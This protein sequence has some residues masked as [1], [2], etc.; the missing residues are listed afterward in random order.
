MTRAHHAGAA[1]SR[2]AAPVMQNQNSKSQAIDPADAARAL[3]GLFTAATSACRRTAQGR[4][5]SWLRHIRA[6]LFRQKRSASSFQEPVA[7]GSLDLE[8]CVM[9]SHLPQ[10]PPELFA[11][12]AMSGRRRNRRARRRAAWSIAEVLWAGLTFCELG[13]SPSEAELACKLGP[14]CLSYEQ[15]LSFHLLHSQILR[16][17]RLK[18]MISRGTKLL[19][20]H[21]VFHESSL[22]GSS[23]TNHTIERLSKTTA[24]PVLSAR[25]KIPKV[26]AQVCPEDFLTGERRYL[27]THQE[28]L[29]LKD[30]VGP[31]APR[32]HMISEVEEEKLRLRLFDAGAAAAFPVEDI[33]TSQGVDLVSGL[34]AVPHSEDYDRLIMDRRPQ[35]SRERRLQWL[36]LPL[37]AMLTRVILDDSCTFRGSGYDLST[38]FSLGKFWM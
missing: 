8:K 31:P 24:R 2:L 26:A 27:F 20:A 4:V 7:P 1:G 21:V 13:G 34:F 9:P 18:P 23:A 28:E 5:L 36:Q 6:Q 11:P 3:D 25:A 22:L 10:Q 19:D 29:Q 38:Y 17:C 12:Q 30:P 14:W 35:H 16:M 32:C 37:G 15:A 33:P